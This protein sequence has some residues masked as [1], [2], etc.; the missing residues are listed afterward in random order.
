MDEVKGG[1]HMQS[2]KMG[3]GKRA[4][5]LMYF[6]WFEYLYCFV[7]KDGETRHCMGC[8]SQ[9]QYDPDKII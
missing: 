7:K 3:E 2:S 6:N 1:V 5:F 4:S 8:D 9:H